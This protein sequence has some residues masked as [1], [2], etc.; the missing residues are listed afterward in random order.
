MFRPGVEDG[1]IA[2]QVV[3]R[4]AYPLV[5]PAQGAERARHTRG[6]TTTAS[7]PI[8]HGSGTHLGA[9][10][11]GESL[12]LYSHLAD[13]TYDSAGDQRHVSNLC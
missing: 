13:L 4:F 9:E 7:D 3:R 10:A 5:R 1:G 11:T 8:V 6:G 2:E 12:P